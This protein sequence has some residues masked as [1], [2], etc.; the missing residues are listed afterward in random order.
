MKRKSRCMVTLPCLQV[1]RADGP[2]GQ[3]ALGA[4]IMVS[5]LNSSGLVVTSGKVGEPRRYLQ[6]S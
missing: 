2:F 6:Q 5:G 3:S 1:V 4:N